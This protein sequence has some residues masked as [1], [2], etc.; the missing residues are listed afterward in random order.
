MTFLPIVERELRVSARK[1]STFWVRIVAALVALVIGSGFLLLTLAGFGFGTVSLG[2]GLF[3]TLTWLSLAAALS[4]GLFFTSDCLSEE[5]REGTLGLLFLTDLCGYDVVLGKLLATS[6]RCFYAL[7]AVLPILATTLLM[8]G[9]TG[10]QF[11]KTS[12]AL[13]NAMFLSLAAG[14]FVSALSRDS[15][16]ALAGTLFLM[17]LLAA[18]GPLCQAALAAVNP[19]SYY[20]LLRLSSPVYLFT[21]A[22]TWGNS[23]F[24]TGLLLNQVVAWLL[25]GCTC[26]VLPRAWQEKASRTSSGKSWSH[27]W[28]FGGTRRRARLRE[29]LID[30]N[31]VFWLACRERWQAVALW[32]M[33][34]LTA[35]GVAAI[36]TSGVDP[37][38][39]LAWNYFGGALTLVIYLGLAS[40]AGRFFIEAQRSGLTELLLA[41]PLTARSIVQGQWRAL[42]RMFAAPLALFLLAQLFAT[43]GQQMAWGRMAATVPAPTPGVIT[44]GTT[45][46]ASVTTATAVAPVMTTTS[47][48]ATTFT[49]SA[50][51]SSAPRGL[52]PFAASLGGTLT[53]LANFAA[54]AWFGMWMGL[55]SKSTNLATLKTILFVQ[56]IPWFVI[57][58][59]S[60]MIFVLFLIPQFMSKVAAKAPQVMTLWYPLI[61]G[62]VT[63]VLSLAKDAWLGLWARKKLHSE[64]RGR[65]AQLVSPLRLPL[66]PPLPPAGAPPV[67]APGAL[68]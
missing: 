36:F 35:G 9:V 34:L 64:F 44:P 21:T 39:W 19:G 55:T 38:I 13:V 50:V 10:G 68:T 16:K 4:A 24:W 48:A 12:L 46:G 57:Y 54:L 49:F 37:T 18:T 2:R 29:K 5:K 51:G 63:T 32:V 22:D 67:I 62:I 1:R 56:I 59:A 47:G 7:L 66:P 28:R 17:V 25:L 11:W 60:M 43:Y 31:P 65:A 45:N 3:A 33:T 27:G 61:F 53:L 14:L 6:L 40:Q 15:Q 42:V 52:L 41:T 20:P 26:A 30:L 23:D 58:F 8:G